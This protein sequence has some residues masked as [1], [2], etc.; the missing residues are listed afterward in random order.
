MPSVL[1]PFRNIKMPV[2]PQP[3]A[4]S[5]LAQSLPGNQAANDAL[6]QYG[7][8]FPD[9][10][11][12][13]M[14]TQGGWLSQHPNVLNPL[15]NALIAA[16]NIGPSRTAGEGIANA[17][18]GILSIR[19]TEQQH[20]FSQ[21]MAP[22]SVAQ[23][24]G[25]LEQMH[26]AN[27]T[28]QAMKNFYQGRADYEEYLA[29][30]AKD[31]AKKDT[32]NPYLPG[33]PTVDGNLNMWRQK[34]DG[35]LEMLKDPQTNQPLQAP[36]HLHPMGYLGGLNHQIAQYETQYGPKGPDPKQNPKEYQDYQLAKREMASYVGTQ[37][38]IA[39]GKT[40]ADVNAKNNAPGELTPQQQ[41]EFDTQLQFLKDKRKD[42]GTS[43]WEGGLGRYPNQK[44][45]QD[46][47]NQSE[48]DIYNFPQ[49]YYSNNGLRPLQHMQAQ[50][51]Q[52]V[53]AGSG[54]P[55]PGS[56]PGGPGTAAGDPF[57][58]LLQMY[59]ASQHPQK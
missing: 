11:D 10:V 30:G 4:Y 34:K 58:Q 27:L 43:Y 55:M 21:F 17:A 16:S 39:G 19:P 59:Q 12:N 42:L 48:Q 52:T 7:L 5:Q 32:Q 41:R 47:V 9:H 33:A 1:S 2:G 8:S 38:Q 15:Q 29:S 28:A 36:P 18:K 22:V 35:T 50:H 6:Q 46:A 14:L 53:S 24:L 25:T 23:Q 49:T 31:Q 40:A 45:W 57:G 20:M 13:N 37:T 51:Q 3:D 54:S 56:I 26:N 44:A